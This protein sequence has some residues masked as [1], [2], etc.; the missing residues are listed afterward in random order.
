MVTNVAAFFALFVTTPGVALAH[1]SLQSLVFNLY[2]EQ[3]VNI[4][5][6]ECHCVSECCC[7]VSKINC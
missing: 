3:T 2:G 7:P 1:C 5:F 6:I 4:I